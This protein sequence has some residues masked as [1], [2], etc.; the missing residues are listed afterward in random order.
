MVLLKYNAFCTLNNVYGSEIFVDY[1][2]ISSG[3]SSRILVV[4]IGPFH[5]KFIRKYILQLAQ[6]ILNYLLPTKTFP[7]FDLWPT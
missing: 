1:G 6:L 5:H 4:A 7:A 2:P 3:S